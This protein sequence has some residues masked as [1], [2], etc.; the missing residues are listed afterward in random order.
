MRQKGIE[1]SVT[2]HAAKTTP[3]QTKIEFPKLLGGEK[4]KL[5]SAFANVCYV[6]ALPFNIW[7]SDAMRDALNK[8]NPAYKPPSRKAV[9]N[10]LLDYVYE[11]TKVEV[12]KQIL[13]IPFLNVISDESTNIN[14]AR[15]FNVSLH[16]SHRA[17]H[18]LSI[19]IG[20]QQMT[21]ANINTILKARLREVSNYNLPRI[22]TVA[23]DTCPTMLA[24]WELIRSDPEFHHIF[25][26]PCD[27]HSLQLLLK[28]VLS[29]QSFKV[30]LDKAQAVTKAFK[31]SPLQY[32]RQSLTQNPSSSHLQ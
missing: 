31:N 9:A 23:T 8:L 17:L 26:I 13:T 5:D 15:I 21:A 30:T 14:N 18:W 27:S 2:R 3:G 22:N 12:D 19:D 11:S 6:Q 28:D 4:A 24:A 7:E 29:L 10:D 20:A 1:N 32:A 25:F 16:T